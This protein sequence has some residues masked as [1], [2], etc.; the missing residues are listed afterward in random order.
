MKNKD[1]I[2]QLVD[3]GYDVDFK[4]LSICNIGNYVHMRANMSR[5]YQVFVDCPQVYFSEVYTELD[6]AVDKFIA[7]R[8]LL[9]SPKKKH[10]SRK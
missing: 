5:R 3:S 9:C 10:E 4:R 6:I 8:N 7:L 2:T 1:A